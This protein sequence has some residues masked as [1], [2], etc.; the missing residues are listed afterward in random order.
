MDETWDTTVWNNPN[1]GIA[2]NWKNVRVVYR[3]KAVNMLFSVRTE[4]KN[5]QKD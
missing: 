2:N 1:C 4:E 3:Y 5:V